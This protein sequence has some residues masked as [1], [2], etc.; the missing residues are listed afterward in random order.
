MARHCR[1]AQDARASRAEDQRKPEKSAKRVGPRQAARVAR[2]LCRSDV[3]V[4]GQCLYQRPAGAVAPGLRSIRG[5]PEEMMKIADGKAP[6]PRGRSGKTAGAPNRS[7]T[8]RGIFGPG[9]APQALV[10]PAC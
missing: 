1:A 4:R 6:W 3:A 7:P 8:R 9:R 5:K 2:R 10:A